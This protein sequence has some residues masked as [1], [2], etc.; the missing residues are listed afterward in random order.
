[1]A[2]CK[3]DMPWMRKTGPLMTDGTRV[4]TLIVPDNY[5][6]GG[7]F[8]PAEAVYCDNNHIVVAV[9]SRDDVFGDVA[10]R[11][12]M[13]EPFTLAGVAIVQAGDIITYDYGP[14]LAIDGVQL[15]WTFEFESTD[16]IEKE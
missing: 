15:P 3:M 8:V 7:R 12:L 10:K 6:K 16:L 14:H 2:I 1:M 11:N 9:Q 13:V 5:E 4:H